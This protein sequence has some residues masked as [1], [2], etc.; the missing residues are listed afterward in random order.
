[1]R[2]APKLVAQGLGLFAAGVV[3][4]L[5]VGRLDDLRPHTPKPASGAPAAATNPAPAPTRRI[6]SFAPSLTECAFALGLGEQVVGV[7]EW[8]VYPPAAQGLPRVG[9][10]FNIDFERLTGLRPDAVLVVGVHE[11]LVRFCQERGIRTVRCDFG[12]LDGVCNV[13]GQLGREFGRETDATRVC[14]TINAGLDAVRQAAAGRPRAK[15]FLCLGRRPGA[16]TGLSTMSDRSFLSQLLAIA[17]GDNLFA[18]LEQDY[19]QISK[20]TLLTRAPDVIIELRPGETFTDEQRAALVRDWDELPALPAVG[21]HRIVVLTDDYLLI[22][23]PRVV[24]IA[25]RL[26]AILRELTPP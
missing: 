24:Q 19:P 8:S 13:L 7:D 4:A 9:G 5:A 11:R 12:R 1:M 3:L 17:G 18:E 20:E 22:P 21:S 16:L 10:Y 26:A 6:V 2:Q 14:A 23:G 15:V 25:E